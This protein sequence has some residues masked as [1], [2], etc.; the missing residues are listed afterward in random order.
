MIL[1]IRTI[2]IS[3]R[4][5]F[6]TLSAFLIG[7]LNGREYMHLFGF[8]TISRMLPAILLVILF[9]LFLLFHGLLR[10]GTKEK[11]F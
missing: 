1:K 2:F 5:F 8:G 6:L 11:E 3:W 10:Y 4:I 7:V 9:M